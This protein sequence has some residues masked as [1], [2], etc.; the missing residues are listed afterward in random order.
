MEWEGTLPIVLQVTDA[1]KPLMEMME[2][3]TLMDEVDTD[4]EEDDLENTNL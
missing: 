2:M 3:M 4:K 1:M